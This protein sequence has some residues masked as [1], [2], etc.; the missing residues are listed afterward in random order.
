MNT[1]L[2][3][4]NLDAWRR[5]ISLTCRIV[6]T[7]GCFDILHAGH[8]RFLA[9]AR[10]EGDLLVV[11]VNDDASV[12]VLTGPRRPINPLADRLELL[13]ALGCV[14]IVTPLRAERNCAL[15]L[16][17]KPQVWVKGGD[18]T[19]ETLCPAERATA[20]DLGVRVLILPLRAGYST[21]MTLS[22]F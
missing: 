2:D 22:K 16:R 13:A 6:F 12:K 15:M 21:T 3:G 5:Q 14:D 20:R 9:E 10:E 7:N 17:V 18:Y 19:L 4:D 1:I 8:T 11:G